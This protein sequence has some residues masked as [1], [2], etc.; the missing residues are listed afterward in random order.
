MGEE[1]I[2]EIKTEKKSRQG[3]KYYHLSIKLGEVLEL[4]HGE[5]TRSSGRLL[6]Y[7]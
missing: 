7:K 2:R 3:H 4:E 6:P 5:S 1:G